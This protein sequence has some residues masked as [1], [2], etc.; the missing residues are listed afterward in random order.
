MRE[1]VS[2]TAFCEMLDVIADP[3]DPRGH[4][5]IQE[6]ARYPVLTGASSSMLEAIA[7]PL[8]AHQVRLDMCPVLDWVPS[9]APAGAARTLDFTGVGLSLVR[10][11]HLDNR[12]VLTT[13]FCF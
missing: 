1:R 6:R 7:R 8:R 3:D 5:G 9:R 11:S 10:G 12:V 2:K 13:P 4:Y